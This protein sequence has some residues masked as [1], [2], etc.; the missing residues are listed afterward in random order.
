MCESLKSIR[1]ICMHPSEFEDFRNFC[2]IAK[3]IRIPPFRIPWFCFV[4]SQTAHKSVQ[5]FRRFSIDIDWSIDTSA[6][7]CSLAILTSAGDSS[8]GGLG[9]GGG[10]PLGFDPGLHQTAPMSP[11]MPPTSLAMQHSPT[12]TN[13]SNHSGSQEIGAAA[14]SPGRRSSEASSIQRPTALGPVEEKQH[15]LQ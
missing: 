7:T 12:G 8:S 14:V 3:S 2:R 1:S 10:G 6:T 13:G 11:I 4:Q 15:H 9:G 5:S